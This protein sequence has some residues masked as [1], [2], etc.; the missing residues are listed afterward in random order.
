M[1][2]HPG[3]NAR[4]VIVHGICLGLRYLHGHRPMVLHGD[5]KPANIMVE[6][7]GMCSHDVAPRAKLL[8]F[9]LARGFSHHKKAAGGTYRWMAP[10]LLT[11]CREATPSTDAYSFGCVA[12]FV[13]TSRIL[14]A[15]RSPTMGLE[16]PATSLTIVCKVTVESCLHEN[17]TE[18]PTM[19]SVQN[20]IFE[21]GGLEGY[22]GDALPAVDETADEE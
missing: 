15:R 12:Y 17:P 21:G 13:L 14:A 22:D 3:D 4:F 5:L 8:D 10:E 7:I 16:W 20:A 18:R 9:G 19:A 11:I 1:D 2:P 6:S